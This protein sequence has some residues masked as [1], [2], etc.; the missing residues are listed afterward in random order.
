MSKVQG[1]VQ[2]RQASSQGAPLKGD[3]ENKEGVQ[4]LLIT[5]GIQ[6]SVVGTVGKEDRPPSRQALAAQSRVP[7][8][9]YLSPTNASDQRNAL[10]QSKVPFRANLAA[11]GTGNDWGGAASK[12]REV[13][14][15]KDLW[16]TD[17]ERL[18]DTS[19]LGGLQI[20]AD[21]PVKSEAASEFKVP[22]HG[23]S[24]QVQ[25]SQRPQK[26]PDPYFSHA[27][28]T[29]DPERHAETLTDHD[30]DDEYDDISQYTDMQS[31]GVYDSGNYG[32]E[33][34][35]TPTRGNE[36]ISDELFRQQ[37][38]DEHRLNQ[39]SRQRDI[40][41][42]FSEPAMSGY[43]RQHSPAT[44]SAGNV[45]MENDELESENGNI[46]L[47]GFDDRSMMFR[48]MSKSTVNGAE[49]P[50]VESRKPKRK[51][52]RELS[53][54]EPDHGLGLPKASQHAA[55]YSIKGDNELAVPPVVAQNHK[56]AGSTVF[57]GLDYDIKTLPNMSYRQLA[58]E[59]FDTDPNPFE[60]GEPSLTNESTLKE[61]LL[62]LHSLDKP[63]EQLQS[64]RQGF[65]SSLPINEYEE[66]GDLMAEQFS[67]AI[68]RFKRARQE[69]RS[70]AREF[71]NEVTVREKTVEKRK[72]AITKDLA[73]LKRAG[74]DVVQGR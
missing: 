74:Q 29:P 14:G 60:L 24:T 37:E 36:Y 69:K 11:R 48:P 57:E 8:P 50:V 53:F 28:A 16:E 68:L 39:A 56:L 12:S 63:R 9:A 51:P 67:Q 7:T 19:S 35:G 52:S 26:P 59:S 33:R 17:T 21:V 47:Q 44:R 1:F 25:I 40:A 45:S 10:H 2:K 72:M 43:A 49:L 41:P 34:A 38:A 73:R 61:K 3:F 18:D 65:F 15:S 32:P 58:E 20:P 70:I 64:L 66:C 4:N 71:E 62:R 46:A 55:E 42:N 54:Q 27:T 6:R 5:M 30:G 31:H 13:R 23:R 22:L